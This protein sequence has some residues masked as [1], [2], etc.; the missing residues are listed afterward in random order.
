MG[1]GWWEEEKPVGF[2]PYCHPLHRY[3][4][5]FTLEVDYRRGEGRG[6]RGLYS[7][8]DAPF[9]F[10]N[11]TH[12]IQ[13]RRGESDRDG[14]VSEG[15]NM[16]SLRGERHCVFF[17]S[18][19]SLPSERSLPPHYANNPIRARSKLVLVGKAELNYCWWSHCEINLIRRILRYPMSTFTL[20]VMRLVING[21]EWWKRIKLINNFERS[22]RYFHT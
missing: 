16:A 14:R 18:S 3:L 2:S 1:V 22:D 12:R 20:S 11:W 7:E 9:R 10:S 21:C 5:H 17:S 4:F 19:A 15:W 8:R 6:G 13:M